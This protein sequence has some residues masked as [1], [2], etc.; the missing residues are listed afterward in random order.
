MFLIS[1][2][3][4]VVAPIL[5][6]LVYMTNNTRMPDQP[7]LFDRFFAQTNMFII[8]LI[9]VLLYGL[10]ATFLINREYQEDTLKTLLTIPVSRMDFI[11]SKFILLFIWIMILTSVAWGLNLILGLIGQFEGLTSTVLLQSFKEYVITGSL[12]FLLT[13][14]VIFITLLFKSFVAPIMF[15]IIIT[16]TNIT[17]IN[18][19]YLSLFPWTAIYV[20]GTAMTPP[21]YPIEYSYILILITSFFSFAATMIY[22]KNIDIN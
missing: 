9:G 8:L 1:I 10:I 3:G 7:I 20:I 12:L 16:I 15:T 18:S 21:K 13:P 17:I 14:P 6:F 4:A 22:F 5:N 19:E 11:L 2:I